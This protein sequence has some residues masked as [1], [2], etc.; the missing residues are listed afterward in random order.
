LSKTNQPLLDI[1]ASLSDKEEYCGRCGRNVVLLDKVKG[2]WISSC[3][4][5]YCARFCHCQ[6]ILTQNKLGKE[7]GDYRVKAGFH[8]PSDRDAGNYLAKELFKFFDEDNK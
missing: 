2:E 8:Y 6:D 5:K 4:N 1:A 3:R 7:L